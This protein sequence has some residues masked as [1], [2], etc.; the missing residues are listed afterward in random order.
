M[1]G[2]KAKIGVL[3]AC[4]MLVVPTLA[5]A[6]A[7]NVKGATQDLRAALGQ[8][9]GEHSVLAIIAMQKG[10][11]AS[12]DFNEAANAL[13]ANTDDLTAA[14]AS[15][16]GDSAGTEFKTIWTSHIGYFVD[17]V[18]ATAAKDE[19][20]RQ[21][22]IANLEEYRTK[23]A[24][25][26]ANAN[27]DNFKQDAIA[28]GLK[29]H[30]HHL[31]DAFDAYVNKDYSAVYAGTRAAYKHMFETGDTLAAGIA[32]QYPTK[33]PSITS[34]Q[35][36][37][38][39]RSALGRLLGE[40]AVLAV[41][42]MQKG[43]DSKPDFDA[44]SLSLSDNTADLTAAINNVYGSEAGEAFKPIWTSHIGYFVNYVKGTAAK[45]ETDRATAVADL[46]TYRMEQAKFFASANP[47]YF[48][49][50]EIA[51]GLN[52]HI[53]H[54]LDSFNHYDQAS[55]TAAY[56]DLRTAYKH[57]FTTADSL[58]GGIVAQ[59]SDKFQVPG[60][61]PDTGNG[62]STG[63]GTDIDLGTKFDIT[64]VSMKINSKNLTVNGKVTTMD[65]TPILQN[66]TT[67][68]PARYWAQ[69]TGG[70]ITFD[71]AAGTTTVT[72]GFNVSVYS[73]ANPT[74]ISLN[75]TAV[76]GTSIVVQDGRVYIPVRSISEFYGWKVGFNSMDQSINMSKQYEVE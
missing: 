44:V 19:P 11:D 73:T 62:G 34:N 14:V 4:L 65:S 30:I 2:I 16:Y 21:K 22:A 27:P 69:A 15:V 59:N 72:N 54:L 51:D 39:L 43:H 74:K 29:M 8:L 58:A 49:E 60:T 23:Q 68:I 25:F 46:E 26:F 9:L 53:N 20:A 64:T 37:S 12:A 33:F 17:Y 63:N 75:G 32:A 36:A 70:T 41:L 76:T 47:D 1:K 52:M 42:A 13:S 28:D 7:Q 48:K 57:M 45:S 5:G 3:L 35:G 24:A 66:G 6:Q 67:Y 31:L 56:S 50:N 61:T 10:Y 55:Y 71:K 40:H 38:D 18:K